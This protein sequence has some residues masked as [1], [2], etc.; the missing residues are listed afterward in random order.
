MHSR[1]ERAR[2]LAARGALGL[3]QLDT[4]RQ[5]ERPWASQSR[6]AA[7]PG[8]YPADPALRQVRAPFLNAFFNH[9]AAE[10]LFAASGHSFLALA[11][12]ADASR[13]VPGFALRRG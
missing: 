6:A 11:A 12:R 13:P 10:R 4:P 8:M 5:S 7:T 2:P 3:I 1:A 9:A